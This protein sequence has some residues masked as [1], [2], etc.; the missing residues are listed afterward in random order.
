MNKKTLKKEARL[1]SAKSWIL[2]Y[3][4]MNPVKGYRKHYGVSL[5]CAAEELRMLGIAVSDSYIS[6]LKI[7]EENTRKHNALKKQLKDKKRM[8]EIYPDSDET[9]Y[10]IAGYTSGGVPYG[11]SWDEVGK[12]PDS[13]S[14]EIAS[15]TLPF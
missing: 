14:T 11:I 2:K 3:N 8:N 12:K 5:L 9:F 4:G 10:F 13:G 1:Q 15:D 6:Q 7:A